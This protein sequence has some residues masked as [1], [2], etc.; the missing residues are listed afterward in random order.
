METQQL[1]CSNCGAILAP[2]DMFCSHCGTKTN[3]AQT[4]G[5]GRQIYIYSVSFL[6]PPFGLVWTWR[7]LRKGNTQQKRVGII[8]GVLTVLSVVFAWWIMAGF[9]QGVQNQLNSYSNVGL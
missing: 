8:A 3:I 4:I 5:I 2:D 1:V 9:L 7:Y 6:L